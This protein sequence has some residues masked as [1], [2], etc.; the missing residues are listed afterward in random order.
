M[1]ISNP[2]FTRRT[3]I[4]TT[5]GA[6][7][8]GLLRGQGAAA[9]GGSPAIGM[10]T[11]ALPGYSLS[12]AIR[13]V[14]ETG[15]DSIEIASMPGYHGAPDQL[16]KPQRVAA[17]KQMGDLG[18]K[19]G[20]LMGLPF[21]D[22]A[23]QAENTEWVKQ[24]LELA[25]D[26]ST[27]EQPLIQ[28]VL[29]GGKWEEKKALFRDTLGPWVELAKQ[30]G[31]RLAI[32]PH[33]SHAMDLPQQAIWLIEQLNA[34]GTLGL[35][36][37]YS[38]FAYRD[39]PFEE[40]VRI[41]LPHTSYV[42]M[43]DAVQRDGK[44]QFA[45]PGETAAIPHAA[46]LKQFLEGGYRGEVCAEVSSQVSKAEG[47]DPVQATVTCHTNLRRIAAQAEETGFT[48]IFNGADLSGWDGEP[49]CWE[50]RD[51]EIWCTGKAKDKNWLIWRGGEPSD[52]TLRLEFRW[53]KGNSGVQVRSD[54]LGAH[55]VFGYQVE[56]AEQG[57]MGLWHHSLLDRQ[58]PKKEARHLMTTAGDEAV[59]SE[60]GER[61]VKSVADAAKVQSHFQEHAWNTMEIL[62]EGPKLTQKIN[63]V[64]F[65][66]LT[67]HD[68]EMSRKKGWIAL[69]DHGHECIVAFRNLRIREA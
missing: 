68:A 8:A 33:R 26:L 49:G 60:S 53:D 65:A 36:F 13:L 3:W 17:R 9:A 11:Y 50:V 63:G 69:Q 20:A 2:G 55:Q 34:S 40:M 56:V 16:A 38:H 57:K 6:S 43:K 4:Q 29:G 27:E 25:R 30:A 1:S 23:K 41:A 35:V 51:G 21:P 52:F 18:L 22:A 37:D 54:D 12:D 32:K 67:D 58:H 42:V 5:V 47:Y 59:I 15:F 46:I 45:L 19:F 44:V 28:T 62:A 7:L 31:V 66:T 14:A 10:G 61:T 48:P 64:V 24:M 39:L